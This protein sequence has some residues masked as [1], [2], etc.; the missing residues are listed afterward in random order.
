MMRM[1][2]YL[3][4]IV[5]SL[6]MALLSFCAGEERDFL[7]MLS[8]NLV[9]VLITIVVLYTTLSNMILSQLSQYKELTGA[10]V[11]VGVKALKRNVKFM[12]GILTCGFFM[13]LV[14][15]IIFTRFE[16]VY[17]QDGTRIMVDMITFFSLFYFLYVIYDSTLG[18]YTIYE[19]VIK[20]NS[21]R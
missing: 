21:K 20:N 1:L 13:L 12:F 6:L 4:Y 2:R 9:P 16:D 3:G 10:K 17:I 15:N 7:F 8:K 5:L 19:E 14:A 18:F 11:E